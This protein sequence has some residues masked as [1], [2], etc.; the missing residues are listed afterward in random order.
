MHTTFGMLYAY[1]KMKINK[2]NEM[3]LNAKDI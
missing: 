2:N 1:N 3:Q